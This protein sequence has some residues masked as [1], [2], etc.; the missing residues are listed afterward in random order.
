[1]AKQLRRQPSNERLT[2]IRRLV[3]LRVLVPV[4]H[5]G[6]LPLL[7]LHAERRPRACVHET[8][9]SVTRPK[10]LKRPQPS[11]ARVP[12]CALLRAN[13]RAR[14]PRARPSPRAPRADVPLAPPARAPRAPRA[15]SRDPPSRPHG[16]RPI[17][18]AF[19]PR[20]PSRAARARSIAS[21]NYRP[22]LCAKSRTDARR[23]SHRASKSSSSSSS[24]SSRCAVRPYQVSRRRRRARL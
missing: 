23:S 19:A 12:P 11:I 13:A 1:V 17:P 20:D 16:R 24:P 8:R 5:H 18:R 6:P 22:H 3:K 14:T 9:A 21:T 15:P 7:S 10:T 4:A 2:L